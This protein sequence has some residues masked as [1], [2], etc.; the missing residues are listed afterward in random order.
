MVI[1]MKNSTSKSIERSKK[2]FFTISKIIAKEGCSAIIPG[3]GIAFEAVEILVNHAKQF[4]KDRTENRLHDFHQHLLGEEISEAENNEFIEKPISLED[5][6][7]L[8]SAAIQ[9]DEDKKVQLYA[10]LLRSLA[11]GIITSENRL[12]IIKAAKEITS[13]EA[14]FIRKFY[15]YNKYDIMPDTGPSVDASSMLKNKSLKNK[16]IIQNLVRLGFFLETFPENY[17]P[18]QLLF[19]AVE[20]LYPINFIK[21]DAIGQVTWSGINVMIV[22]YRLDIHSNI[23]IKLQKI[24][25]EHRIKSTIALLNDRNVKTGNMFHHGFIF[26]LDSLEVSNTYKNAITKLSPQKIIIKLILKNPDG[27]VPEDT[28]PEMEADEIMSI[29]INSEDNMRLFEE[30]IQR[31]TK[32]SS[33]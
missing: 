5:Y 25:R 1:V 12:H 8:L 22:S 20:G 28:L 15:I 33:N 10:N 32:P 7:S 4:Y 14:E 23:A 24:L 11:K 17:E 30:L 21:P 9:D 3:G 31:Y 19:I 26:L 27:T 13:E 29:D 18:T 16:I 6:Y 2:S